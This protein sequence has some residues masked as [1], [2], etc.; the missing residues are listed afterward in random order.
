MNCDEARAALSARLDGEPEP[1][2]T[3]A[4]AVDAHVAACAD[5][6]VW[7]AAAADLNR[8]LRMSVTS[9]P[10]GTADATAPVDAGEMAR[11]MTEL[12]ER[13]PEISQR[14]RSRSLPLALCRVLM[15]VLAVIYVAWA[16]ILLVNATDV[17]E[18]LVPGSVDGAG[19]AVANSGDPDLT[20]LSVDAATVRLAL[21]AG[22]LWGA[23]RPRAAP[24]LLPVFLALWGFG[25]GFSTRDLVLGYLDAPTV[26]GLLLH[27]AS[28]AAVIGVWL[29]RHHAVQP[30]RESL[31]MLGALPVTYSPDDASRNSTWRPG[32]GD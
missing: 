2:G 6:Q 30:L 15:V 8:R 32:D 9:T 24:G 28:C 17:P 3:A 23:W 14:L 21:A 19:G 11:R 13:T 18:S 10:T 27:L 4:D 12:A 1:A 29:A 20:S 22:L 16:V 31:R 25:A 5:C 7:F 26:A